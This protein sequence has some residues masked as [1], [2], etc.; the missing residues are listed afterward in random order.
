[1][2][3]LNHSVAALAVSKTALRVDD[4]ESGEAL[5]ATTGRP[6]L[7]KAV[8]D[9]D[10]VTGE[11]YVED[12]RQVPCI[13]DGIY[14]ARY[15]HC[16]TEAIRKFRGAARLFAHFQIVAPGPFNGM[17]LYGAWSVKLLNSGG[18]NRIS[19]SPQ[20]DLYIM[21]CRL[22]GYRIRPDRVSLSQ[23]KGCELLIKTRT[24]TRNFR[25]KALPECLRYSVVDDVVS[26][27]TGEL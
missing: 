20:S 15:L 26:I 7:F 19:I 1:M 8:E 23:L 16:E 5:T 13:S 6:L 21:L 10:E 18:K 12:V 2:Q 25:Q 22:F 27:E 14:S 4:I 24:V 17:R 9:A 11:I 3:Q